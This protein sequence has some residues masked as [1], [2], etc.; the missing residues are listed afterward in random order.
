MSRRT[1]ILLK[2]FVKNVILPEL[3]NMLE[4]EVI[5]LRSKKLWMRKWIA[6]RNESSNV[7]EEI[8]AEDQKEFKTSF[9]MSPETFELLL[10]KVSGLITKNDTNMRQALPPSLKLQITITYLTTGCSYTFLEKFF[11]VSKS[12]IS[13]LI[14]EVCD[15]IY[16]KLK[17]C[18]KVS[19]KINNI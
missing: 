5:Q 18:I 19:R 14:P 8:R 10:S 3:L 16:E 7:L 11:R 15:A 13:Q 6:R 12:A 9:R 4:D 17:A 1:K 2:S